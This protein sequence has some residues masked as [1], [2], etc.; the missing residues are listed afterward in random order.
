MYDQL[1]FRSDNFRLVRIGK[2]DAQK[3]NDDFFDLRNFVLH[4][5][6]SYPGI[7]K[8]FDGK[9]SRGLQTGERT[10]F[11]GL[12]NEQPIAAAV[13]KKGE[14]AKFCHL[15]IDSRDRGKSLGDLF[16]V[17]MALEVRNRTKRVRFTLPESVWEDRKAFF[18]DFTF[19]E[20]EKS[21]RQY[22]LFDT[23]LYSQTS[24]HNL[25]GAAKL[26]L[27]KI[28]GH[29][30]MGNHSLL[31]GAVLAIQ[32]DPL[33]KI[34]SGE[35]TVEIRTRFSES[36]EGRRVSLYG[37]APISGL[38]GE[39]K[40][41]KIVHADPNKIWEL[42]GHAIG[43]NHREYFAYTKGREK[44]FALLLSD[45]SRF[46]DAVPLVQISHLL[47]INLPAPQSYLS[48]AN[49]DGWLSAVALAAALQGSIKIPSS[50]MGVSEPMVNSQHG[51]NY[52]MTA[53]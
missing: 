1:D 49:S 34:L 27:P 32:P 12:L 43:C 18:R 28:F 17:M 46:T 6:D 33:A 10:G 4:S 25:Y 35:K 36:W 47:G 53:R 48:L 15:R 13:L 31:T 41:A 14:N 16:F 24:F 5:E 23:E 8:W 38:A 44:V 9:V 2:N 51:T 3:R 40:I 39:A 42:W 50:K 11:V 19:A 20:A 26:K 45:V 21:A 37:T 7:S 29:L 30:A 52:A 22:R